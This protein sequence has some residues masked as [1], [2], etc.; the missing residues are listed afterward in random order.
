MSTASAQFAKRVHEAI[1][2][3]EPSYVRRI[4]GSKGA[5]AH[6][7]V[8]QF[9][10]EAEATS[11]SVVWDVPDISYLTAGDDRGAFLVNRAGLY[12]VSFAVARTVAGVEPVEIRVG[13]VVDNL[14]SDAKTRA[15]QKNAASA[16]LGVTLSWVGFVS[17]AQ[18]IWLVDQ[19]TPGADDHETQVTIARVG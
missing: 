13:T 18:H 8:M 7:H 3:I 19:G 16:A 11:A 10:T 17:A 4:D 5:G 14:A 9:A 15:R 12:A 6:S 2:R 1:Q